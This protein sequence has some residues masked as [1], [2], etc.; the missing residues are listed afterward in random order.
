MIKYK[1]ETRPGLVALNDIQPGNG[2]GQFLQ[3]WSP[4]GATLQIHE[5]SN[6]TTTN[7]CI[8]LQVIFTCPAYPD[9]GHHRA[10]I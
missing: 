9:T 3:H 2:V 10:N 8:A 5:N 1:T 7:H 4:H 6:H